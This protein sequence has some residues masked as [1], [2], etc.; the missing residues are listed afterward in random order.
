MQA[1]KQLVS[2]KKYSVKSE[3]SQEFYSHKNIKV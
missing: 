2:Y 1:C 3:I